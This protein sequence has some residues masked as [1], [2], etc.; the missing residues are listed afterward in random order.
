M[1]KAPFCHIRFRWRA[2][3]VG[4]CYFEKS[5]RLFFHY[6]EFDITAG[7]L[8][9]EWDFTST[10]S[11]EPLSGWEWVTRRQALIQLLISSGSHI[12]KI[13]VVWKEENM[14]RG[15]GSLHDLSPSELGEGGML[16]IGSG[17]L[18][19]Q[20]ARSATTGV[21]HSCRVLGT[22]DVG[23]GQAF[24]AIPSH[25]SHLWINFP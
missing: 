13:R 22:A 25:W 16:K 2:A 15:M 14:K 24:T 10:P 19:G 23:Q 7:C 5:R 1:N 9:R 18:A 12:W 11:R 4:C 3:E 21:N 6:G 17:A 8:R 20:R